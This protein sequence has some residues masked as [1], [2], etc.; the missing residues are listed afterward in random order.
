M[1]GHWCKISS[2]LDNHPK[3]RRAG[4]LGR[5]VFLFALRRNADPDN[6]TPGLLPAAV[7][8]PWFIA[9]QLMMSE[10]EASRGVTDAVTA[11]LLDREGHAWRI[12]GWNEDWGKRPQTDAERSA[13]YRSNQ[14]TKH[15][16]S[17]STAPPDTDITLRHDDSVTV[18]D[19]VTENHARHALEESRGDKRRVEE[20]M[21]GARNAR[22]KPKPNRA[23]VLPAGWQPTDR[24]RGIAQETGVN[25]DREAEA[26]RDHHSAKGSRF[27]DWDAAFRTWLRNATKFQAG[28][29]NNAPSPLELQLERVRMLEAEEAGAK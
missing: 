1:A 20:S 5:E 9:D 15:Q 17:D 11:G 22:P 28:K 26:F 27:V 24:E 2:S 23:V 6:P 12:C 29:R 7:M 14:R 16:L 4:R 8:E 19:G 21:L 13:K 10:S 18:R 25:C 3:I